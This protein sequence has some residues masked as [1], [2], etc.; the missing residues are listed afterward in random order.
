MAFDDSNYCAYKAGL[1]WEFMEG[2]DLFLLYNKNV[3]GI[4]NKPAERQRKDKDA[5]ALLELLRMVHA[6]KGTD[7]RDKVFAILA[8]APE[9]ELDSV[10]PDNSQVTAEV[11]IN[12]AHFHLAAESTRHL[13][14]EK[15]HS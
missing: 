1:D 6:F 14:G 11:Y 4:V 15:K 10:Y 3:F 7:L 13:S 8:I 2:I 12:L 5:V 9:V